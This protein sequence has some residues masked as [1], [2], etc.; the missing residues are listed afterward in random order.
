MSQFCASPV[1][2]KLSAEPTDEGL[3]AVALHGKV[4]ALYG[5]Q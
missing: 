1:G 5:K 4:R 3:M 2:E